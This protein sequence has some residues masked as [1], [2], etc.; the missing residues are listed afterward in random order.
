MFKKDLI[1]VVA[2]TANEFYDGESR[3]SK[4]MTDAIFQA[5]EKVVTTTLQEDKEEKIPLPGLGSFSARHVSERNG[6]V[7]GKDFHKDAHDKI[8]FTVSPSVKEI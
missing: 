2:E 1:K 6:K 4:K 5:L 8:V 7:N 3:I